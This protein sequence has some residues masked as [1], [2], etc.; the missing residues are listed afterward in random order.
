MA[1]KIDE[2]FYELDARTTGFEDKIARSQSTVGNFADFIRA[3]P[4]LALAALG[5]AM[6]AVAA[7][8]TKMAADVDKEMRRVQAA[9]PGATKEIAGLRKEIAQLS[10]ETPRTQRELAAAAASIAEKGVSS[11]TE[12]AARLRATAQIADATGVSLDTV[13]DGIDNIGDAFRLTYPDAIKATQAIF[14]FAQGKVG[15]DEVFQTLARGGAILADLGVRAEDAGQA[16]VSLIDAGVPRR[17]AGTVLTTVLELTNRVKE[18][19]RGTDEQAQAGKIIEDTLSR[20]NIAAK[21]F[22]GALGELA[23]GLEKNN[24]DTRELGIRT[25]T[26]TA[27][28]RVAESATRDHR[29]ESEKLADAQDRLA[30]A[31]QTNRE[32]A[33]ALSQ[34]LVNQLN[35][36]FIDLGNIIL[37]KVL[38][39]LTG[40]TEALRKL[41]GERNVLGD[42]ATVAGDLPKAEALGRNSFRRGTRFETAE[43][44]QAKKFY[45]SLEGLADR[46]KAEGSAG[47]AG[48]PK[49]DIDKLIA[50][51]NTLTAK[52]PELV[53]GQAG[54]KY[55]L[56]GVA[57]RQASAAAQ[58]ATDQEKADSEAARLAAE[59]DAK[60]KRVDQLTR[61]V[62]DAITNLQGAAA[63]QLTNATQTAIDDAIAQV[64]KFRT[65]VEQLERKA[66]RPLPELQGALRRA[67]AEPARIEAKER[68]DAA[69]EVA[70]EV[71]RALG[72]QSTVMVQALDDFNAQVAKRNAEYAALG[73]APL[74]EQ[75]QL[76]HIREVRQALID[77]TKA[78]EDTAQE[79]LRI[80]VEETGSPRLNGRSSA[81]ERT[82]AMARNAS[83]AAVLQSRLANRQTE[84]E[85]LGG[86]DDDQAVVRRR[87]L[88]EEIATIQAEINRLTGANVDIENAANEATTRRI[89]LL[90]QQASAISQAVD[91]ATQLAGAFGI[92]SKN[93][94]GFLSVLGNITKG[95]GSIGPFMEKLKVFQAGTKDANG[96]PLV[97]IGGL[98][99]AASP[100]I[101][102]V[103]GAV[104]AI[105]GLLSDPKAEAARKE[106]NEAL[107][108]L[109][110]SLDK[111]NE[112]YLQT[113]STNDVRTAIADIE[114]LLTGV[115]TNAFGGV[116]FGGN[117][118][119]SPGEGNGPGRRGN[120]R[121][122]GK[123][124]GQDFDSGGLER[125]FAKLDATYGTNLATFIQRE[126][127]YGLLEALKAVPEALRRELGELGRYAN[128]AAGIIDRVNYQFD[129]LG[130]TDAAERFRAI[131]E[132]LSTAGIDFGDFASTFATLNRPDATAEER[133]RAIDDALARLASGQGVNFG[134]LTPEEL[135]A[136]L[137][138]GVGATG[139]GL[140]GTGGFNTDRS[141][142][143]VTGGRLA[144][145]FST[146]N[147]FAERTASATEGILAILGGRPGAGLPALLPPDVSRG[148][149][150]AFGS[151][152]AG[153]GM[154]IES[155][156]I[157]ISGAVADTTTAQALGAAAGRGFIETVDRGLAKQLKVKR[158]SVGLTS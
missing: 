141:I 24:I 88:L 130:K 13:S 45:D 43:E 65:E 111:L 155:L 48:I 32:E 25:N 81:A 143:E 10:T 17:Q 9:F 75:A 3:K 11:V 126:D 146:G 62:R 157:Q 123:S 36:S 84:L 91:L 52:K 121:D 86:R 21:G 132:A 82:A 131:I 135:R 46:A 134:G 125:Y 72:I 12:I 98:I 47:F 55:D 108:R 78:A 30:K 106:T 156:V 23:T 44:K 104:G 28:R 33:G 18:L 92:T 90:E 34:M 7:A 80:K 142:T 152:G 136:L 85:A 105:K 103:V 56:L 93:A 151:A 153:G 144:A 31:A 26:L 117:R 53:S 120:L 150:W 15:I 116:S 128:T 137:K 97:G 95:I 147:I 79:L 70:N 4:M 67:E 69:R 154:T 57:L 113:V 16:M 1:F 41:R 115:T 96:N 87:G 42:V 50:N 124:L 14:G 49:A 20:G 66:G 74:F 118:V 76:D 54:E 99:G 38:S 6:L 35:R 2:L 107:N 27:I 22:L 68:A 101:G 8:A 145:L 51:L 5:A 119:L 64:R 122:I 83:N 40:V 71:S 102:G 133:Q 63:E 94:T 112:T 109:R 73:K 140:Q 60:K 77:T 61:E 110:S 39:L 114:R 58:A 139:G 158:R 89:G 100:I 19:K 148:G 29:T 129:V 59:A 149:G 127:P 138:Q 37:P